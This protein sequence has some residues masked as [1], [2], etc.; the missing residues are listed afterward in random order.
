MTVMVCQVFTM[1]EY[2]CKRFGGQRIR[3][4]LALLALLLC[5]F[6]KIAVYS[7]LHSN[8]STRFGATGGGAQNSP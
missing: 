7:C 8:T 5:V 3:V 4:Y 1:P 6:T 2:M